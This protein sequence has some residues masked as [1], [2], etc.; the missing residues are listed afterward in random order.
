MIAHS[1]PSAPAC[2]GGACRGRRHWRWRRGCGRDVA[3]GRRR[4][5]RRRRRVQADT[6]RVI[7]RARQS[8]QPGCRVWRR[9]VRACWRCCRWLLTGRRGR[10]RQLLQC[11]LPLAHPQPQLQPP[12]HTTNACVTR[13]PLVEV[14]RTLPVKGGRGFA[15][16]ARGRAPGARVWRSVVCATDAPLWLTCVRGGGAGGVQRVRCACL[17]PFV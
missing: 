12:S 17:C 8:R 15:T 1:R 7:R 6:A 5:R 2:D 10:C 16:F 11:A 3:C 4:W 14:D 9:Q 13:R